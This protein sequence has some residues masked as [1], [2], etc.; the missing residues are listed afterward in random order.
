[1]LQ[2][3]QRF[4][5]SVLNNQHTRH[6]NAVLR[7]VVLELPQDGVE[8]GVV[9][10]GA[11][12]DGQVQQVHVLQLREVRAALQHVT[13]QLLQPRDSNVKLTRDSN[14]KLTRDSNVK[15]TRDSNVTRDS[16]MKL[17]RDSNVKLTRDS[18]VKLTRDS[19]VKL[20]RD[21][22]VKTRD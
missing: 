3:N 18:N 2:N 19:N 17:T 14:V 13:Q 21:S 16:N 20:T 22:N 5:S 6:S 15:L 9:G 8:V 10:S 12:P 7:H 11:T 1:M 4:T